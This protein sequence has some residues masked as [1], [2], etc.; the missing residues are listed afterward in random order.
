MDSYQSE[1]NV[2]LSAD[3]ARHLRTFGRWFFRVGI[4]VIV[5]ILTV[6]ASISLRLS[7]GPIDL[8]FAPD[9]LAEAITKNPISNLATMNN[10]A[11]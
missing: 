2:K 11:I 1:D 7:F 6:L 8:N 10:N 5:A 9:H 4:A 3:E